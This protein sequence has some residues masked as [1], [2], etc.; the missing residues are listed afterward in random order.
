LQVILKCSKVT[1]SCANTNNE[2]TAYSSGSS[3]VVL[4]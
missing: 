3:A 2:I 1:V 4:P